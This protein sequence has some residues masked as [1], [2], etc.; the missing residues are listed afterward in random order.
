MDSL[1]KRVHVVESLLQFKK[2]SRTRLKENKL[3]YLEYQENDSVSSS[4][5]SETPGASSSLHSSDAALND[6]IRC[7]PQL[8]QN[9]VNNHSK[10]ALIRHQDR[11]ALD[12]HI[13]DDLRMDLLTSYFDCVYPFIPCMPKQIFFKCIRRMSPLLI[14]SMYALAAIYAV[15]KPE[16][17]QSTYSAGISFYEEVKRI[18]GFYIE[19]PSI[20]TIHALLNLG[21][22]ASCTFFKLRIYS[23]D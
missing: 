12:A 4:T 3:K 18:L 21:V 9:M 16:T 8:S 17:T 13:Y 1:E 15:N 20:C 6:S 10:N 5:F 7:L 23:L 22:Y 19:E 2:E 14:T 11:M